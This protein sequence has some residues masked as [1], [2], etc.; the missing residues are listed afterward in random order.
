MKPVRPYAKSAS[1][2]HGRTTVHKIANELKQLEAGF[3]AS[4]RD[5]MPASRLKE[6]D[7]YFSPLAAGFVFTVIAIL[8]TLIFG[9]NVTINA[10]TNTFLDVALG[11]FDKKILKAGILLLA[12]TAFVVGWG[13]ASVLR[14]WVISPMFKVCHHLAMLA[15]GF[16]LVIILIHIPVVSPEQFFHEVWVA[17]ILGFTGL[18]S[19]WGA[20]YCHYEVAVVLLEQS[21]IYRAVLLLIGA[22][23]LLAF[24]APH[25]SAR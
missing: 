17:G 24:M 8:I 9:S 20:R 14:R 23:V 19:A 10:R 18:L 16:G 15:A 2:V 1:V 12:F 3:I 7:Y 21:L 22:V 4:W 13:P 5:C 11:N 25:L 6:V